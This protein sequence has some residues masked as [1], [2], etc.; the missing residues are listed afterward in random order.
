MGIGHGLGAIGRE[1]ARLAVE[2]TKLLGLDVEL[3]NTEKTDLFFRTQIDWM[4]NWA[5]KWL[6]LSAARPGYVVFST[7]AELRDP[8]AMFTRVFREFGI[9]MAVPP[10]PATMPD[11]RRR[12]EHRPDWCEGLTRETL[13]YV[14]GV[15]RGQL[16][17]F[18]LTPTLFL[19]YRPALVCSRREHGCQGRSKTSRLLKNTRIG[20][21]SWPSCVSRPPDNGAHGDT[22]SRRGGQRHPRPAIRDTSPPDS[23]TGP[24]YRRWR[25]S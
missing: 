16:E 18:E 8:L 15:V 23:A 20:L 13:E 24:S 25:R 19:D 22:L 14:N 17:R 12:T 7:F 3:G 9:S 2:Q 4:T 21:F 5:V 10:L 6:E 11:D 1:R